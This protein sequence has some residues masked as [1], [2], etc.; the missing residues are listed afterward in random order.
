MT[1][2]QK[3][4]LKLLDRLVSLVEDLTDDLYLMTPDGSPIVKLRR[5]QTVEIRTLLGEYRNAVNEASA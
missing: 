1:K 4:E 5:E 2:L 3:R